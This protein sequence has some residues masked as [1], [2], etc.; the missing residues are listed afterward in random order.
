MAAGVRVPRSG[1]RHLGRAGLLALSRGIHRQPLYLDHQPLLRHHGDAAQDGAIARHAQRA[2]KRTRAVTGRDVTP[3][4]AGRLSPPIDNTPQYGG[5][6]LRRGISEL[7]Q[8]E[9][10]R[11]ATSRYPASLKA[12]YGEKLAVADRDETSGELSIGTDQRHERRHLLQMGRRVV[13]HEQS[14]RP[15]YAPEVRPPPGIFW[16]LGIKKDE[17]E[18]A[19]G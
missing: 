19:V 12:S 3:A 11:S 14:A 9:T 13:D 5:R 15:Q 2:H 16:T 17:I 6:L 4:D 1:G 8:S 7:R 18:G 10:G